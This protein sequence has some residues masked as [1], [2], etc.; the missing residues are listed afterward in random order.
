MNSSVVMLCR[1]FHEVAIYGGNECRIDETITELNS[2]VLSGAG[3][4]VCYPL[5][6]R[7]CESVLHGTDADREK[8]ANV[9][10]AARI[11]L[12][13]YAWHS[14]GEAIRARSPDLV[15][16]G[17]IA[18]VIEGGVVDFRDDIMRLVTRLSRNPS[19][20]DE[21]RTFPGRPRETR[22]LAAFMVRLR[23][24]AG[25]FGY[26]FEGMKYKPSK[27]KRWPWRWAR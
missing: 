22:D 24:G 15:V 3:P 20:A 5:I 17:L 14:A 27:R 26:E 11:P 1:P 7:L 16:K 21:I 2:S 18:L 9:H 25:D 4:S 12:L 13:G 19:L 23:S 10:M 8:A 6:D